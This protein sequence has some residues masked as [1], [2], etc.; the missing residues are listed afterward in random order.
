EV[1]PRARRLD[2][3]HG[4]HVVLETAGNAEPLVAIVVEE[5]QHARLKLLNHAGA[6]AR[7]RGDAADRLRAD[8]LLRVVAG[9]GIQPRV[10]LHWRPVEELEAENVGVHSPGDAA[11][12]KRAGHE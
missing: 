8:Q 3:A 10:E 7:D 2:A 5:L 1:I 11:D 12:F 6:A 9:R 4:A